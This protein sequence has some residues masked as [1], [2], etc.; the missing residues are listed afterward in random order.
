MKKPKKKKKV[1]RLRKPAASPSLRKHRPPKKKLRKEVV[2][3]IDN[4]DV[5]EEV[6]VGVTGLE[7]E[8][9]TDTSVNTDEL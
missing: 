1:V 5:T 9:E 3:V 7:A 6:S 2:D 4:F 8:K